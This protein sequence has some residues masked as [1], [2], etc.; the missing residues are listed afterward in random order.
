MFSGRDLFIQICTKRTIAFT[1][2]LAIIFEQNRVLDFFSKNS[3]VPLHTLPH[4]S[5]MVVP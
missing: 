5:Q 4:K 1:L 3:N 2:A